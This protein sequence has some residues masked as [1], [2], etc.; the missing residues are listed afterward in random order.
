MTATI[1]CNNP[2]MMEDKELSVIREELA[3]SYGDETT[4][5]ID[6]YELMDWY[7]GYHQLEYLRHETNSV[8]GYIVTLGDLGLWNGRTDG[9]KVSDFQAKIGDIFSSECDYCR[10][11]IDFRGQIKFEGIH[12]DGTNY[13]SYWYVPL[14]IVNSME[15]DYNDIE[16]IMEGMELWDGRRI[17][18]EDILVPLRDEMMF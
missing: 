4:N 9:Y 6:D 2:Y 18:K 16:C 8:D 3:D 12:H 11:Y 10:W 14:W 13:Y 5:D 17:P 7:Y 15:L 1:W